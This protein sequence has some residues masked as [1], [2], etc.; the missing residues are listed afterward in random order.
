[1]VV[2]EELALVAALAA[3]AHG[4]ALTAVA[5]PNG[6]THLGGDV[7]GAER[8]AARHAGFLGGSE[9]GL[10]GFGDQLVERA[11]DHLRVARKAMAEK[12]T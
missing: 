5:R 8:V 11:L 6:P 2:L 12:R 7:V 10:L 4:R 1:V 9:L 3:V